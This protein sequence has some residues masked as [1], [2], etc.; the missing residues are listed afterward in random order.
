MSIPE[1]AE[2]LCGSL[3]PTDPI[4]ISIR[5][6][7]AIVTLNRPEARN[8]INAQM[9]AKLSHAVGVLEA[10]PAVRANIL[11]GAGSHFCAG[12]D[13]KEVAAGGLDR[14]FT[15]QGGLG[16]FTH[17]ERSKPW[18]AAVEGAAM[19]GGLELA[20]SCDMVVASS[21]AT[22]ALPEVKRGLMASAGGI[23]RLPRTVPR[24]LALEM[25][26][27]G[28][29][30]DAHRAKEAGLLN[31]VT[32]PGGALECALSLA[33]VICN[34]APLAVHESLV[35]AR[36]AFDEGEP[37]LYRMGDEAQGRLKITADFAEGSRAF[38]EK[39]AP[40]WKGR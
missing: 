16:G 7:I 17:A 38:A 10:D 33:T 40:T 34:N 29:P 1:R 12:A 26:A 28:E 4:Q 31:R 19:A 25:I 35:L 24:T 6:G 20:L 8:A 32:E 39:R 3:C 11:T 14:L 30:I 9:T 22:F 15:R 23:Y 2:A 5:G 37:L 18:L 36:R 27:T 13:L 21:T